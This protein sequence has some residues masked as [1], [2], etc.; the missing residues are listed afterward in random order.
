M[1]ATTRIS[2]QNG[3]D[4]RATGIHDHYRTPLLYAACKGYEA[5]VKLLLETD[6]LL[7]FHTKCSKIP[8]MTR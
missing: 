4:V 3:A 7:V 1:E 2:I 8:N 5:V 6:Y